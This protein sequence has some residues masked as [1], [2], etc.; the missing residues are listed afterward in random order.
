MCLNKKQAQTERRLIK[1]HNI[2]L[3]A[4]AASRGRRHEKCAVESSLL[5]YIDL[6]RH[7]KGGIK[8]TIGRRATVSVLLRV[9]IQAIRRKTKGRGGG[10]R[11]MIGI[12][13]LLVFVPLCY[14]ESGECNS[15][16]C[17]F[18][19]RELTF[20]LLSERKCSQTLV[21]DCRQ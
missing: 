2:I 9:V 1:A 7:L 14:L 12:N 20:F 10:P 18:K 17:A 5:C 19:V 8:T 16:N 21:L 3:P 4:L 13:C 15:S 11:N 6:K